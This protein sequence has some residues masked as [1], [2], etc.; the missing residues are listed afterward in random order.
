MGWSRLELNFAG[1]W[2]SRSRVEDRYRVTGTAKNFST[3]LALWFI[4][5]TYLFLYSKL[6]LHKLPHLLLLRTSLPHF[7]QHSH[8][9]IHYRQGDLWSLVQCHWRGKVNNWGVWKDWT[10]CRRRLGVKHSNQNQETHQRTQRKHLLSVCLG[11]WFMLGSGVLKRYW[12][13]VCDCSFGHWVGLWGNL[14]SITVGQFIKL[15]LLTDS[16]EGRGALQLNGCKQLP[17]MAVA[18]PVVGWGP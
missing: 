2:V 3:R 6:P 5:E 10:L 4:I 8:G 18:C 7:A 17:W 9:A 14:R 1:P 12:M 15:H 11:C 16:G 13:V